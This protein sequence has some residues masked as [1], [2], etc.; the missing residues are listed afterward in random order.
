MATV[1]IIDDIPANRQFLV[2]L[3]GYHGHRLIQAADGLEALNLARAE[4]P[5]LIISDILMPT[6][7]GYEF[8]QQSVWRWCANLSKCTGARFRRTAR[9]KGMGRSSQSNC[10]ALARPWRQAPTTQTIEWPREYLARGRP[11]KSKRNRAPREAE[12]GTTVKGG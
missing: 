9:L 5:D 6:M 3:L 11:G 1:L 12:E 8:V 2:A 4:R 10:R 7:D